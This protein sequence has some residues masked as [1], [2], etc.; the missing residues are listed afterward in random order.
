MAASVRLMA[1]VLF[2]E[3][4][5]W[6][7]NTIVGISSPL[8]GLS[9][10][11]GYALQESP[12]SAAASRSSPGHAQP[13]PKERSRTSESVTL[14]SCRKVEFWLSRTNTAALESW[15]LMPENDSKKRR[16]HGG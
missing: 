8:D 14:Q 1:S 10:V 15:R 16:M 5:F 2:P 13:D 4:P 11:F 3:P 12:H 6:V 7:V 9:A